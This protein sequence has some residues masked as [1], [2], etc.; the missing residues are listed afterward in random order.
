[1]VELEGDL[2]ADLITSLPYSTRKR[3]RVWRG[4]SVSAISIEFIG[5]LIDYLAVEQ[6]IMISRHCIDP[7][8]GRLNLANPS[9]NCQL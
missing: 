4:D 6:G 9:R 8:H 3:G 7:D 5:K 2:K 1:M